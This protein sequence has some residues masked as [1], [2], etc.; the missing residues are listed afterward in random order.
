MAVGFDVTAYRLPPTAC[1]TL[2]D[3]YCLASCPIGT[4]FWGGTRA[5]LGGRACT[6]WRRGGPCRA[7]G[8]RGGGRGREQDRPARAPAERPGG[9]HRGFG[10]E[11]GPGGRSED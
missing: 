4:N 11:S 9:R 7:G 6:H 3:G 10:R 2:S 1:Y 8:R 5:Q